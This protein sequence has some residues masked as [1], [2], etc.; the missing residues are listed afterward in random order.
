MTFVLTKGGE[1]YQKDLGPN[2]A[3]IT[4]YDANDGWTPAE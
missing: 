4:S 2:S 1:I 3:S